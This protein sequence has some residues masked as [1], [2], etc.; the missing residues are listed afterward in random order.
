MLCVAARQAVLFREKFWWR[1]LTL[2]SKAACLAATN[3][4]VGC[5]RDEKEPLVQT[6]N[7][8]ARFF[9]YE[10]LLGQRMNNKENL[11]WVKW[12]GSLVTVKEAFVPTYNEVQ[13]QELVRQQMSA[14]KGAP[15]TKFILAHGVGSF[16][17]Q[18][19]RDGEPVEKVQASVAKLSDLLQA[20]AQD[21][22]LSLEVLHPHDF[23]DEGLATMLIAIKKAWAEGKTP[24]LHGDQLDDGRVFSGESV[25]FELLNN[26]IEAFQE[27]FQSIRVFVQ[28]R[29]DGVFIDEGDHS[30]IHP[31]LTQMPEGMSESTHG[32][33]VSGGMP[34]KVDRL[35]KIAQLDVESSILSGFRSDNLAQA[36]KGN[37]PYQ[38]RIRKA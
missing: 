24:L 21:M 37:S 3:D 38:T 17:H 9:V 36:M 5:V 13:A 10:Y 33:D 31:V 20:T 22:G 25:F 18:M 15:H 8:L 27:Q 1:I 12:G 35:L 23:W 6:K 16:G 4:G 29:M 30:A 2:I 28:G 26:Q 7:A 32:V 11:E 34:A 14:Q 19:V